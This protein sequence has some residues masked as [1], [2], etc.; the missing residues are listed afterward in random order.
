[1]AAVQLKPIS[2]RDEEFGR[3]NEKPTIFLV[4][5]CDNAAKILDFEP[6]G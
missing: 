6:E 1:M 2:N 4:S 5:T 3:N